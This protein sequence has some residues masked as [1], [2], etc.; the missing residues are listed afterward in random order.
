MAKGPGQYALPLSGAPGPR[1]A[2]TGTTPQAVIIHHTSGRG[3]GKNV[4]S[5]WAQNRPGVGTQYIVERDGTVRDVKSEFGYK[6]T[7]HIQPG[8][9]PEG[10]GL[11]SQNT[12]GYEVVAKNDE[13]VTPA[14]IEA[15]KAHVEKNYPDVKVKGHEQVNPGHREKTEGMSSV[16]SIQDLRE[17][18]A[19][20]SDVSSKLG[21]PERATTLASHQYA[22]P[23]SETSLAAADPMTAGAGPSRGG[24]QYPANV[25]PETRA[26]IENVANTY[27]LHPDAIAGL[28]QTESGWNPTA[29]TGSYRGL[30]QIGPEQKAYANILNMKPEQQVAAYGDWL[31]HY[32]FADKTKAAGVDLSRM[33]PA[34]QAAYL[35]GF[36]FGPNAIGWQSAYGQGKENLPVTQTKQAK[37]LGD[38]SMAAMTKYYEGLMGGKG[39]APKETMVASAEAPKAPDVGKGFQ[40]AAKA[41]DPNAPTGGQYKLPSSKPTV[42]D[43]LNDAAKAFAPDAKAPKTETAL[44]A[45]GAALGAAGD[46]A[47][48]LKT[49]APPAP[50]ETKVA[51]GTPLTD[52]KRGPFAGLKSPILPSLAPEPKT[53]AELT[54]MPSPATPEPPSAS[55]VAMPNPLFEPMN[56]PTLEQPKV[57]DLPAP[58]PTVPTP[59]VPPMDTAANTKLA[60]AFSPASLPDNAKDYA[61]LFGTTPNAEGSS[62]GRDDLARAFA[63]AAPSASADAPAAAAAETQMASADGGGGGGGGSGF[64]GIIVPRVH[65]PLN[66]SGGVIGD[67]AAEY[68][69]AVNPLAGVNMGTGGGAN[70]F[71]GGG[72]GSGIQV[73]DATA[74]AVG[75]GGGV[76]GDEIAKL[77]AKD[78]EAAQA[79]ADA[80]AQLAAQMQQRQTVPGPESYAPGAQPG[81]TG[82][83]QHQQQQRNMLA[84]LVNLNSMGRFV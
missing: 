66:F 69:P 2:P 53:A 54:N 77:R 28:I 52:D 18:L 34:Q 67:T 15:V 8:S 39:S 76:S 9:G 37:A 16:K 57:A 6:G 20:T 31:Q 63:S 83:P 30:T 61:S 58:G 56:V 82:S 40:S 78:Q 12:V 59:T 26:A 17:A 4:V 38:T 46:L 45:A 79:E 23:P 47:S 1:T 27:G 14:Q 72:G 62:P 5:D 21:S 41:L 60:E 25:T 74:N 36:Q 35:Q 84:A 70:F 80:Q 22:L 75:G 29:Q 43:G 42:A 44:G 68:A 50:A 55:K 3:E 24:Y 49:P 65:D 7:G 48:K 32:N 51:D 13:D 10:K 33:S 73:A 64:G 11:S 71:A 19:R 81:Q